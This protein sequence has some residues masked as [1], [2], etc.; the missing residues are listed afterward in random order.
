MKRILFFIG[1]LLTF[2]NLSAQKK[3]EIKNTTS[4]IETVEVNVKFAQ[5]IQIKNWNKKEVLVTASA[6]LND[7][8]DNEYFSLKSEK[9]GST[10]LVKSDYGSFFKKQ[11]KILSKTNKDKD[12][13]N[14]NYCNY[15][16]EVI[17]DYTIYL[18]EN[19]D[20]K[21]KSI[22]G[23]VTEVSYK[24]KLTL[25]LISGDITVKKH[26]KSMKLKTISGDIDVYIADAQFKAQTLTG[27]VY[28]DLNIDFDKRRR[29]DPHQ[30]INGKV[31]NGTASLD[32][33]TISGNIFLRKI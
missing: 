20:L 8:Q 21:V 25:D 10:Y 23:N 31:K 13:E 14:C 5:N 29:R 18:P 27:T 4:G 6:N 2:S 26:S 15:H 3:T 24:G 30:K 28:S 19:V 16:N 11:R 17:V 22:S 1:I 7:N 32:L 9:F 33:K 12:C